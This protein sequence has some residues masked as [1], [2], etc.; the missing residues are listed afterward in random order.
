MSTQIT[1][2]VFYAPGRNSIIDLVLS[3]DE[4]AY[5]KKTI[6]Q[7]RVEDAD[8]VRM[9][10]NEA[11]RLYA[12][13]FRKPATEITREMFYQQYEVMPPLNSRG[14]P[15]SHSF[16]LCELIAADIARIYCKIG[17]RFFQLQD[18]C[19]LTHAQILA[20]CAALV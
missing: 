3:N 18:R 15:G 12:E 17:E 20:S 6:E 11:Y 10:K 5:S 1:D 13:G 19:T 16:M 14:G 4:G 7:L 9:P 8:L 2:D